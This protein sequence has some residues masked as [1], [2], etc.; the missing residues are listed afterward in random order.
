[1]RVDRATAAA[2]SKRDTTLRTHVRPRK[3]QT[4][5]KRRRRRNAGNISICVNCAVDIC[6]SAQLPH[7]T[8]RRCASSLHVHIISLLAR[9]NGRQV[10]C[11]CA[12]RL[13]T[14]KCA[15]TAP[16]PNTGS[17]AGLDSPKKHTHTDKTLPSTYTSSFVASAAVSRRAARPRINYAIDAQ[18]TTVCGDDARHSH[19]YDKL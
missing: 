6:G 19:N 3:K 14:M 1:M 17:R 10:K 16:T 2:L 18:Y 15:H 9:L 4:T 5:G 13:N 7:Q 12:N 8:R 11:V